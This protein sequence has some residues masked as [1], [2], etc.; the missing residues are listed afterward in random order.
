MRAAVAF[1]AFAAF[2]AGCTAIAGDLSRIVAIEIVGSLN[3]AVE[4]G[5]TLRLHARAIDAAGDSVP[6]AAIRWSVLDTGQVGIELDSTT[7]LLT[8]LGPG[9]WRVQARVEALVSGVVSVTVTPRPDTVVAGSPD[10]VTVPPGGSASEGLAVV[11]QDL[12][13]APGQQLPLSD[14]A[15]HFAVVRPAPGSPTAGA[16]FLTAGDTIPGA[17]PHHVVVLTD[18]AGRATIVARRVSGA[19]PPDTVDVHAVALTATGDTVPGSPVP[20][21]VVFAVN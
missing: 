2:V 20:F 10:T 7:G 11:V 12:T 8:A 1:T 6:D 14:K 13:T 3:P 21:T 16:I 15:V 18:D 19:T 5:D 9:S 17:E 4:E